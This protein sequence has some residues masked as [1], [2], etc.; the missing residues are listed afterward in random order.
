MVFETAAE[1][2]GKSPEWLW[3]ITM[4]KLAPEPEMQALMLSLVIDASRRRRQESAFVPG[5]CRE[6]SETVSGGVLPCP[7]EIAI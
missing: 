3:D 7:D 4:Q 2:S 1:G 5:D 6:Q